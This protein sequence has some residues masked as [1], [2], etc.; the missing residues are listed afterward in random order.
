MIAL[1]I[2]CRR[3]APAEDIEALIAQTLSAA[4]L[5]IAMIGVIATES[6]KVSEPGLVEAVQR[7]ARPLVGIASSE[8]AKTSDLVVTRSGR[9]QRLKGVPSVAETAAL[10]AVGPGGRLVVPRL[11][12]AT[13]TCAL[14]SD[15][16][17]P[18]A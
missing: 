1:G 4:S 6:G 15:D 18:M 17:E 3:N 7:L 5:S 14:A 10:A 2:G 13:V 11:A 16:A 8:L 9:V 12:N